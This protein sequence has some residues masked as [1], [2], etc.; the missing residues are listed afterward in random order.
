[1]T[2][3]PQI[4]MTVDEFLAWVE[5][6]PGRYELHHGMVHAMSPENA[7]HAEKKA[8]VYTALVAGIRARG[9]PSYT[10]PDGMTVRIDETTAFEPDALVYCG[11]K[12]PSNAVVVP[13]P[14]IVVEVLSFSTRRIN[15]SAKLAGYFKLSSAAHYLIVD[16]NERLI[17]HHA[18]STGD[19]ILMHIAR[20]PPPHARP[21]RPGAFG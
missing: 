11:P 13:N 20:R 12:L 15:A 7:G 10:L 4:R 21:A 16:L 1:M 17:I 19:T 3:L 8:A 14:L 2:V 6:E 5:E 18:R 9:L